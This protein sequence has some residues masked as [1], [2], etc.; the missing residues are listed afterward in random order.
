MAGHSM[1]SPET[2]TPKSAFGKIE[3]DFL[4]RIEAAMQNPVRPSRC[5]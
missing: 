1:H 4:T 2:S 3:I 5:G